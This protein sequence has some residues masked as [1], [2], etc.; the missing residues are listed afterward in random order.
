VRGVDPDAAVLR[1]LHLPPWGHGADWARLAKASGLGIATSLFVCCVVPL[2]IAALVGSAAAAPLAELDQPWA[3]GFG[4]AAAGAAAWRWLGR[5]AG[6]TASCFGGD[7][8]C[9]PGC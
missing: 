2:L 4:A 1:A 7:R 8:A 9:G 6:G 3:I 5:R